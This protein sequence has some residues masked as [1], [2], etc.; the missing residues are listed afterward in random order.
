M[1]LGWTEARSQVVLLVLPVGCGGPRMWA[2][3][4]A[5]DPTI[6]DD[7]EGAESEVKWLAS[8]MPT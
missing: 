2:I 4:N 3:E 1:E 7:L 8:P 5:L 6:Q